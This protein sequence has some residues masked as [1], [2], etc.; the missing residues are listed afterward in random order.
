MMELIYKLKSHTGRLVWPKQQLN[1][2]I[3]IPF[4]MLWVITTLQL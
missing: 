1:G 2:A 4:G 3:H